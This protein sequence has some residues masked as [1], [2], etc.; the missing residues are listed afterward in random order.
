LVI[1]DHFKKNENVK[2]LDHNFLISKAKESLK[3]KI[4]I[5]RPISIIVESITH[6]NRMLE[7]NRYFFADIVKE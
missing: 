6:V 1:V 3:T 2:R 7:E 5:E 4:G